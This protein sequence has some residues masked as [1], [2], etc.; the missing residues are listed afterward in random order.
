MTVEARFANHFLY[1][2]VGTKWSSYVRREHNFQAFYVRRWLILLPGSSKFIVWNQRH[3][4]KS[5]IKTST[6]STLMVF[7]VVK[8]SVVDIYL[9]PHAKFDFLYNLFYVRDAVNFRTWWL[10]W[11][12]LSSIFPSFF[13]V[14]T[15]KISCQ[16]TFGVPWYLAG[17]YLQKYW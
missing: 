5:S 2:F 10:S 11:G 15:C 6:T 9:S 13:N 16:V 4:N 3:L 14:V 7:P 12:F 17:C 8:H 1:I